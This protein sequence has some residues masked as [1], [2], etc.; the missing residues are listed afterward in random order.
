MIPEEI[1]KDIILRAKKEWPDDKEMQDHQISEEKEGYAKLDDLDFTDLVSLKDKLISSARETFD[2]WDEVY[3]SVKSELV[4]YRVLLNFS[5]DGIAQE[6]IKEW[7][8][9]AEEENEEYYE[10]QLKFL[11]QKAKK[12]LSIL[13]T[14]EQ[15]DPMKNL[16][17]E[18]EQIV[19][20]ECYNGNIQ[21]YGS[22]GELESTGR[23]FRYV[24][25]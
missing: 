16:L 21:N 8:V 18:L 13:K 7:K 23:R 6:H 4:A 10:G 3:D 11:E 20:N 2:A 25:V 24:V 5:V 19:G 12:H 17:V 14:R 15:I 9:E 22:W 1:F